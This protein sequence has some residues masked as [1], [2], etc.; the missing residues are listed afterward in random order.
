MESLPIVLPAAPAA[1]RRAPLPFLAAVVPVVGGVALWLITGSLFALCFAAL[2]PLMMAASFLDAARNRRRERRQS[3]ADAER[4]WAA[5]DA[6]LLRRHRAEREALWLRLPD[7]SVCLTQPPLRG[8]Q[9]P[10]AETSLVVGTGSVASGVRCSGG[11]D[12]RGRDFRQRSGVLDDA[13]I[14]VRLGGG[15]C[16]RGA[17]PVIFAVAR[18]L[19]VQLGL[20]FGAAQLSLVGTALDDCGLAALPHARRSRRSGFRLG[21]GT[22]DSGRVEADALIWLVPADTE[23]PE[24]ITTVIDVI[25]PGRANLRTPNGTSTLAV[26]CLSL[27]Q[28]GQVAEEHAARSDGADVLPDVVSLHELEQ[29]PAG[30][31]LP[32]AIG[33]SAYGDVMLDIVEDGPHA[34]VTGTTGTGKSELLVSWVTAIAAHHGPDRVTFLLADFKGGM[35]FEPLRA[36][37]QVAAVITD[38]DEEGAR[39]GVSSLTAELRRREALLAAAGARDVREV[40]IPRLVIVVDEFAALLAEHPDLGA[41]FI[42]VAARGRALGMH[43]ILGTQRATGVVRDALAANCPLRVSLRVGDAADSRAMIGT[44]AAAE[45]PGGAASR[46]VGLVRRPSDSEPIAVRVALTGATEL[47]GIGLRWAET[48]PPRSPWLPALPSRL[49]LG[50]LL[51]APD[52]AS[53]DAVILGRADEPVQQMQPLETLH[54]GQERGLVFLGASGSGRTTALRVLA[55]QRSGTDTVWVPRDLEG[56]WDLVDAWSSGEERVPALVLCDDL[57]ALVAGFPPDY[58][59]QFAQRWEHLLRSGAGMTFAVTAGR[60]TGAVGR[61]LDA[62]P[63]RA[64]LRMATRVEHLAAGGEASAFL[65]DRSPGRAWIGDRE[66]QLAWV[67]DDHDGV[68]EPIDPIEPPAMTTW[69][70]SCAVTAI[71]SAGA[72]ATA[73]RLRDAHAGFEVVL[74][75]AEPTLPD[76]HRILIADAETW[77]RNWSSWQRI[78][79]EGEVVIRAEQPADLR[80][81]AG[82]RELPPFARSHAGRAWSVRGAEPP[83]RVILAELMP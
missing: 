43:L 13:P 59:Q 27:A 35:A 45:L 78:R 7:A 66:V 68:G 3:E 24:G 42:D 16:I 14:V 60:S 20:R 37:R 4:N 57:D 47:R 34:I 54:C 56:A 23:V 51:T 82:V 31:G 12:S 22:P 79:A 80:Q 52:R 2:G 70:P 1:S 21:V 28:V 72:R 36:L 29:P 71:V 62:L 63:R 5:A 9:P 11:D 44:D 58:G 32:A 15:V 19:V 48:A 69:S 77:Q 17:R 49:P 64:L 10:D 74:V 76:G 67:D 6:D 83:R 65:R 38:L 73:S 55:A 53:G 40:G 25:E 81:L 26:E 33:R 41:V 46:G 18:A 61:V 30:E 50:D 8:A 75:G 39:R